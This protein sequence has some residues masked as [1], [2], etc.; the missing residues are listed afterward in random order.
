MF[1][2]LSI[3]ARVFIFTS[4]CFVSLI[5]VVFIAS[6]ALT[7]NTGKVNNLKDID[8]PSMNAASMNKV[9]LNQISERFNLAVSIGDEELLDTNKEALKEIIKSLDLM[10][11]LNP[12]LSKNI[13]QITNDVNDYFQLSN[14]VALAMIDEEIS[15]QQAA[16]S[17]KEISVK[18]TKTSKDFADLSSDRHA[19]FAMLVENLRQENMR[20]NRL[21]YCLGI[22]AVLIIVVMGGQLGRYISQNLAKLAE[23]MRNIAQGD[24][25]LS[26][27]IIHP[28]KDEIADVVQWFNLFIAK[29]NDDMSNIIDN[30]HLTKSAA[31][32]LV[33]ATHTSTNLSEKQSR[34]IENTSNSLAALFERITDIAE[35]ANSASETASQTSAEVDNST[36]LVRDTMVNV[37]SLSSEIKH[38]SNVIGQLENHTHDA[39]SIL[40]AINAIAEQTN[41]L[42]LN[43]AIE[44]ARAGEQGR[45]FAVVANE[46]RNLAARTQASTQEIK[47][48]LE[49]LQAQAENAASL[50]AKSD[51]KANLCAQQSTAAASALQD[52][53]ARVSGIN[54][55]NNIIASSTEEQNA[56][57]LQIQSYLA[58]MQEMAA[59]ANDSVANVE[60]VSL[61]IDKITTSLST[62][63][64]QFIVK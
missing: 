24:G 4:V 41:L 43:A 52:I 46:V 49:Q 45:G 11:K 37:E 14:K 63:T 39:G 25:D 1:N 60:N 48:V 42:A 5:S 36:T 61:E 6:S 8:Y 54:E 21:M 57:S 12:H 29:L 53:T 23:N 59:E 51:S 28:N 34:S 44:A 10:E 17:A 62:I 33:N 16:I 20:A 22:I 47:A 3:R 27:R 26:A 58:D 56:A 18:L 38:A 13:E 40:E 55:M 35:N 2:F 15:L 7:F 50:M 19:A 30:I 64:N 31:G 9:L 32:A